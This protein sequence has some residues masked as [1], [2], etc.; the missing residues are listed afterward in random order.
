MAS[1]SNY[2]ENK[3]L[4]HVLSG[5]AYT[6][7]TTLYVALF[8]A[9]GGLESGTLTNELSGSGYTRQEVTFGAS[10]SGTS[11]NNAFVTW[12]PATASW[13]TV[14][15]LAV[16]DAASVGQVLYHGALTTS[17]T[18]GIGDTFQITTGELTVSLD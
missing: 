15:H 6:A 13:G 14:T 2:L 3:V 4:D 17:K 5:T 9:D 8:T 18:V 11:A 10:A 12:D 1:A 16:M 7:P